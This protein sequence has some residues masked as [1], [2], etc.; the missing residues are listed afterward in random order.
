MTQ[1][2]ELHGER[3]NVPQT[4]IELIV[5]LSVPTVVVSPDGS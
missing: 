1:L 2:R 3:L 4:V 5:A